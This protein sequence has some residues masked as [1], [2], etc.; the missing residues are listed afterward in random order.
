MPTVE[1]QINAKQAQYI[2]L[3]HEL[4]NYNE[5]Y[6]L[7]DYLQKMHNVELDKLSNADQRM[8]TVSLKTRQQYFLTEYGVKEYSMRNNLMYFT[9]LVVC[10]IIILSSFF[11]VGKLSQKMTGAAVLLILAIWAFIVII[12]VK[13]NANRRKFAYDQFYW[14]NVTKA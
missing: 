10:V 7:N 11:A 8:K 2:D 5:I 13:S 1:E 4:N 3:T 9:L 14:K 6:N 12:V